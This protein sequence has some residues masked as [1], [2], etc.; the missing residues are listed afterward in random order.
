MEELMKIIDEEIRPML[1]DHYGDIEVISYEDGVFRFKLIGQCSG[2][3][4]AKFTVE[5]IIEG[6]L[7]EKMPDLKEVILENAVSE[8]LLDMARNILN[9]D[10]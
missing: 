8:E 6:P 4:S 7:R 3:P 9:K 2:C 10:K 5:D 1:R